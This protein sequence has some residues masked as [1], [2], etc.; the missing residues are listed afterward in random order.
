MKHCEK[1]RILD[2]VEGSIIIPIYT[3]GDKTN[4]SR[5]NYCGISLLSTSNNTVSNILLARLSPYEDE[6]VEE[7]W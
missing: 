3:K 1:T 6:I 4:C 7:K 2:S 5:G